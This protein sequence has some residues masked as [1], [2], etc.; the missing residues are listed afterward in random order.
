M[1]ESR[2]FWS[3]RKQAVEAE[4][5]ADITREV[6]LEEQ[7]ALEALEKQ[8][9]DE[10]L[11]ELGLQ[12]PDTLESGDDFSAFMA[13]TVPT[14]LRNRAL[15]KLWLSDPTLANLDTLVDYGED[16]TDSAMAVENI[17]TAYQVGK[18]MLSHVMEM[19]RQ[20]EVKAEEP[21][22]EDENLD[23]KEEILSEEIELADEGLKVEPE[24]AVE[25][26]AEISTE[27]PEADLTLSPKKRMRFV[28]EAQV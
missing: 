24:L 7:D 11:E 21:E 13:K 5:E 3:R 18:G 25:L 8:S 23:H 9:D 17:Q 16:F 14:R 4:A 6:E 10:I 22:K 15:R 27:T 26:D 28:I 20:D 1:K 19:A 2:D 12:D